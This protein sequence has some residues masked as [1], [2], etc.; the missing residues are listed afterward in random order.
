MDGQR[1]GGFYLRAGIRQGCQLS[2]LIFAV[3]VDLLLRK[4]EMTLPELTRRA[5]ADDL[6]VVTKDWW[7]DLPILRTVFEEFERISGLALNL[8]K[9]LLI[10]LWTEDHATVATR[11][12]NSPASWA[13]LRVGSQ[14]RYLGFATGPGKQ[15]ESWTEAINKFEGRVRAWS[16]HP[17]GLHGMALV[18]NTFAIR[19]LTFLAQLE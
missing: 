4:L 2:P 3:V 10:P 8:P 6:A 7:R 11:M 19:V 18:Y 1:W 5:F 16:Q 9:T 12:S 15:N 14:G 17:L 13:T